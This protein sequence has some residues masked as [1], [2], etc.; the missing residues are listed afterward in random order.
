MRIYISVAL[1]LTSY[2]VLLAE[3][4]LRGTVTDETGAS[5]SGVLILIHWDSAGSQV[6]LRSNV[7]IKEDAVVRTAADG[8]FSI[9][10]PSGFYD[11]FVSRPAF[12]PVCRKV[13]ILGTNHVTFNPRLPLDPLVTNELGDR[14]EISE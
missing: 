5:I 9:D 6:G 4:A 12:M 7:G 11:V 13:R 8:T 14:F 2:T 10:L 3:P 1:T